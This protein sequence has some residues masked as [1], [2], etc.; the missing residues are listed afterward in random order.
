MK[1]VIGLDDTPHSDKVIDV[2]CRRSWPPHTQFRLVTVLEPIAVEEV[3]ETRELMK[4]IIKRRRAHADE[5]AARARQAVLSRVPDAIV[6]FEIREG[7]PRAQIID[8]AVE[9]NADRI[10][11]GAHSRGCPRFVLGSVSSSVATHAPCSVEIVRDKSCVSAHKHPV[12]V[13]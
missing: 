10:L 5:H 2:V 4:E 7:S 1:V 6:A 8:A 11:L 9:W 13:G 12:S 3:E